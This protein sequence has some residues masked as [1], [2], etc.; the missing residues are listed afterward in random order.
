MRTIIAGSRGV[1]DYDS[2]LEAVV[3]AGFVISEVVSGTARGVDTL[4]EAIARDYS[5]P[6][7]EFPADW[8]KYGRKAGYIRNLEMAEYA[9][10]LIA[11]W[12]GFSPGTKNMINTAKALGLQVYIEVV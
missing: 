8:K 3:N 9:D 4:G 5:I 11:V 10:A 6:V 7:K 12:D 1:I 2:V